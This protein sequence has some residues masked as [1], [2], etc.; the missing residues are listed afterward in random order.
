M[1]IADSKNAIKLQQLVVGSQ[2]VKN[3][4]KFTGRGLYCT[5]VLFK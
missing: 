4:A 1:K 3:C 2:C 5:E